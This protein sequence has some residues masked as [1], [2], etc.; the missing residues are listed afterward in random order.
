MALFGNLGY[1]TKKVE[2]L[3]KTKSWV[4]SR[5]DLI[6]NCLYKQEAEA[7]VIQVKMVS[8]LLQNL[9]TQIWEAGW[10]PRKHTEGGDGTAHRATFHPLSSVLDNWDDPS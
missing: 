2:K 9:D 5:P 4:V 1:K 8:S 6:S 10:N 7:S 3:Q